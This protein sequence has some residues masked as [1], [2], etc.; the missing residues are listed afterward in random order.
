MAT[1][2]FCFFAKILYEMKEIRALQDAIEKFLE[3][4]RA[5]RYN[6]W[7]R[8]INLSM[9]PLLPLLEGKLLPWMSTCQLFSKLGINPSKSQGQLVLVHARKEKAKTLKNDLLVLSNAL[10]LW[11]VVADADES[12]EHF[13][14]SVCAPFPRFPPKI[15]ARTLRGSDALKADK[16]FV[17]VVRA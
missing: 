1:L 8:T 13:W 4:P 7:L 12:R 14:P 2:L 11:N 17:S 9:I 6:T 10:I 16:E 5:P 3:A 15:R